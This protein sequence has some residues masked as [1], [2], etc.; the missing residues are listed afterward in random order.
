MKIS[1]ASE[2]TNTDDITS[3]S[4]NEDE[5]TAKSTSSNQ[6]MESDAVSSAQILGGCLKGTIASAVLDEEIQESN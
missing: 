1:F 2:S 4:A 5:S 3:A 6:N